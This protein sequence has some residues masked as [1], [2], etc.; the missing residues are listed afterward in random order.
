MSEQTYPIEL[1]SRVIHCRSETERTK[2]QEARNLCRDTRSSQS[3]SAERLQEISGAC[4]EYGL[5]RIG[6]V[7]AAI[8]E[9]SKHRAA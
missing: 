6:D 1:E 4:R 5:G 3:Y 9:Q 7:V 2:L 8:A